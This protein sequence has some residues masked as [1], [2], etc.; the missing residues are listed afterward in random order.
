[1]VTIITLVIMALVIGAAWWLWQVYLRHRSR[2]DPARLLAREARQAVKTLEA[3]SDLKDTV[4]RCY[5]D[6]SRVLHE[7][8]GITRQI[9]MTPREFEIHLAHIGFRDDH[10]QRLTRLFE[11]V[12]YGANPVSERDKREAMDCLNAIVSVYGGAT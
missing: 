8:R 3:G 7:Q 10:I 12:R 2:P 4:T 6:M 11:S 9:A 1:L 5:R